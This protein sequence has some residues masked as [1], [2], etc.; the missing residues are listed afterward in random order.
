MLSQGGYNALL[1]TLEEPPEHVMFILATTNPEKM[2]Q[3]VMSRCMRLD[4]K[5]VTAKELAEKMREICME[6]GVESTDEALS[7]LAANA[8]GSV[9]DALSLLEQ[10]LSGGDDV[11]DRETVLEYYSDRKSVV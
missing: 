1:K 11:I 2:P 10:C 8:D 5:R 3:T 7:L 9:R 6:T 4:F